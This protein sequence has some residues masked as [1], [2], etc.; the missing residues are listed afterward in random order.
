MRLAGDPLGQGWEDARTGFDQGDAQVFG[1]DAI[2]AVG[3]QLF[4]GVAQFGR[5]FH[6]G[7]AGTDDGHFDEFTRL[8]AD[9]GTKVVGQQLAVE[10]LG[11]GPG[12]EE[13]AVFRGARRAEIVG[14]AADGQYQGVIA[15]LPFRDQDG[16][17]VLDGGQLHLAALAIQAGHASELEFEVIPLGL[18]DIAQFVFGGVERAG[19]HLVQQR[20]PQVGGI[21]VDQ[22]DL[23]LVALAQAT[24]QA[25]SQFQAAGAAADD[26]D[27]MGHGEHSLEK[28][29]MSRTGRVAA[30]G[31]SPGPARIWGRRSARIETS[32]KEDGRKVVKF[33]GSGLHL[34]WQGRLRRRE[35]ALV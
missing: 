4:G 5:Q 28:E 12:V 33:K 9:M 25:G 3:L 30:C 34:L 35:V 20:F 13:D 23:R 32:S 11:L 10:A 21:G 14:G 27:A 18:G 1:A 26:N 15:D 17:V 8:L 7:G 24:A 31:R 6:A 22:H 16:A 29:S 19:G 2:H